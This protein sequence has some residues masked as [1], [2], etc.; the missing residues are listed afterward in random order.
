ME[1]VDELLAELEDILEQSRTV[2]FSSKVAVNRDEIYE[3][4]DEIRRKLPEEIRQSRELIKDRNKILI[5]AQKEADELLDSTKERITRLV[6][7]HE[8]SQQAYEHASQIVDNAKATAKE[9]R[10]GAVEY[11]EEFLA[12]AE[13]KLRTMVENFR[14]E[15]TTM[16][17]YFSDCLNTIYENIQ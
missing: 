10:I 5:D 2:P 9:M 11:A 16:D 17:N 6:D 12:Q 3:I 15:C 7:S 1:K 4:I 13:E 8:I 14:N